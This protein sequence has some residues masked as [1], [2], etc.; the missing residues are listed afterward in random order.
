MSVS[1]FLSDTIQMS[2]SGLGEVEQ[3][4]NGYYAGRVHF[5]GTYWPA[6]LQQPILGCKLLPGTP[7]QVHGREGLTLLV[8]PV[9]GPVKAA[10]L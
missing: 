7:V 5:Q 2:F 1:T 6:R 4:I 10:T 3:T 9:G 8:S